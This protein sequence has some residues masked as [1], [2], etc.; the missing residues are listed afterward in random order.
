MRFIGIGSVFL[1]VA[2]V[3]AGVGRDSRA[4]AQPGKK[5]PLDG[6]W[7]VTRQE[8]KGGLV[9]PIVSKRL[10]MVI[11]DGE[12]GWYIGNP[13]A[14]LTA[15]IT[16]NEEKKTVDAEITSGSFIGKKML[17]IYRLDK[18]TLE[19]CWG[20][21]G[22]E[23]RPTK[24]TTKPGAGGGFNYTSYKCEKPVDDKPKSEPKEERQAKE[25]LDGRWQVTRQEEKGGLVPPI[26]SKR[27][28]MVIEDGEMG[29]YIGNPAPNLTATITINAEKKTIDAEITRGSFFGKTMLGIYR[30]N[31]DTLEM[32][33][34][35][36]GTEKRPTKFTTKPGAGGGFNYTIYKR[37]KPIDD[38][39]KPEGRQ[40]KEPPNPA[41]NQT[42]AGKRPKLADLKFTLPKGWEAKHRDGSNTWDISHG[43]F[44]PSVTV[45]WALARDY[46][47]DLN[48]Y[49][50][51]LQKK[52]DHFA[53]GL[54]WTSVTDKGKLPDGLYVVGK[55][56][57][58]DDK[59]ARRIGFS[60][61]RD[62]GGEKVLF[63]S[64]S[65]Y[66]DDAK[67]LKQAMDICKSAKF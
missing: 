31:K 9:P 58:K 20:E 13:A 59:E 43:G 67:L 33:W 49:V 34:G 1:A 7:Q 55:A 36:I 64:F 30:L 2:L 60:F 37:E 35:E 47:K 40:A 21:I 29:W 46:P 62:L 32:C 14:N 11:E 25:S 65:T 8:E 38:R 42:P 39:P 53:Y 27:L 52:G 22:T 17:G 26:V 10:S 54:Y 48:D 66:Y 63:E 3:V 44:T 51:R 24:F 18:D 57:L 50:E 4:A 19:M 16:I 41:S 56:Q 61:I 12:M 6:R 23:K 28:S 15:T 45:G 5:S